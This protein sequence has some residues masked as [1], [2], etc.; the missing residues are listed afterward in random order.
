MIINPGK[1][2]FNIDFHIVIFW[3]S[4]IPI[5]KSTK[6]DTLSVTSIIIDK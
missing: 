3:T 6:V 1:I 5:T 4:E 2:I